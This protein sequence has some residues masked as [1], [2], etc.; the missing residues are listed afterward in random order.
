MNSSIILEVNDLEKSLPHPDGRALFS[1][2]SFQLNKG[3]TIAIM[4]PSGVGKSSLLHILGT[5]DSHSKGALFI[6]GKEVGSQDVDWIR[7]E[8]IGFI[9][10]S[11]H[12]L[13][14]YTVIENVLM[15]LKIKRAS[16]RKGSLGYQKAIDLLSLVGL[17]DSF[18]KVAKN[19]S[20]GEKQRVA[21]ARALIN[22]PLLILA[23]EPTGNLDETCG[24]K[25]TEL[26]LSCAKKFQK[27]LIVVTHNTQLFNQCDKKFILRNGL[28]ECI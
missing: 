20:G 24:K 8:K 25:V 5:L 11:Y 26:L 15:P 22:D 9:F 6:E 17:S 13:E 23:D 18:Y 4:G 21:I 27:G 10:Q 19:L 28:L 12:L 7:N 3:E 14:D 1:S 16:T 2:V